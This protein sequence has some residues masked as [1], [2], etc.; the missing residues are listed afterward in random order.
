MSKDKS[1]RSRQVIVRKKI[2]LIFHMKKQIYITT[3][4]QSQRDS[5]IMERIKQ[6]YHQRILKKLVFSADF[7]L[8]HF[9]NLDNSKGQKRDSI[10][11]NKSKIL[12]NKSNNIYL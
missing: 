7:L 10:I 9:A 8:F 11:P 2:L 5:K 4:L 3:F 6:F 12:N 1:L